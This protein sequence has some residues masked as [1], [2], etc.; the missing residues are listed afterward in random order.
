MHKLILLEKVFKILLSPLSLL[1]GIGVSI[2]Q[3][4]FIT[5]ISRSV[6]FNIP[7]I[8]V[9]NLSV[10]GTGKSPHIEY[11]IR[12]LSDYIHV[13]VLS[14]GYRRSTSGHLMVEFGATAKEV[15]DEPLQIK[16]KFP[17]I[18][19]AV[20][21]NRSIGIPRLIKSHPEIQTILL[22]DAFQHWEVRSYL[23]ILLTEF[24]NPYSDDFLI[25]SG[26]L[27]EWRYGAGRAQI[28]VVTKC[29]APPDEHDEKVWRERLKLKPSQHL[30][31][32]TI[33]YGTPYN[34]FNPADILALNESAYVILVSAIAQSSYLSSF[35]A[36]QVGTLTEYEF[37]DHHYF[38]VEEIERIIGRHRSAGQYN[39]WILTTEKDATRLMLFREL[40]EKHSIPVFA[41]PIEV[42]F[43]KQAEFDGLIKKY[44][45]D[46][47]S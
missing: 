45:L 23:Q 16:M 28:V 5:G 35:L 47:K 27:R 31:F 15:G 9:G 44:L 12:L 41:V 4:L 13:G 6:S 37:E 7:V 14:R 22:D 18:P 25:P 46:F 36:P 21:K 29:P 19:V 26:R 1:Y 10:G 38:S 3:S 20:N 42:K 8:S 34:I 30:F 24:A 33:R 11:L 39:T 2:Y 17:D 43:F 32:S 40:F